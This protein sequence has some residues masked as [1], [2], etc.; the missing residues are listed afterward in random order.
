MLE[1]STDLGE[2]VRE[3]I[4]EVCA[5]ISELLIAKNRKYGNS[6]INPVRIF[7]TA[8]PDEQLRVR[9]DDKLNRIINRQND[10]DEDPEFDLVG[11]LILLLVHRK[12]TDEGYI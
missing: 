11:Y 5:E 9:L 8:K 6:A 10:E 4:K 7:S 1:K 12:L 2:V 3:A